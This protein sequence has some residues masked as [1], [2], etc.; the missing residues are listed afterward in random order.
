MNELVAENDQ[1]KPSDFANLG[2]PCYSMWGKSEIEWLAL[3]YVRA[4]A[5]GGDT[6]RKLSRE[7]ML[8]LLTDE[9]KQRGSVHCSVH[10][11]LKDDHY[12]QWFDMVSDQISD[13]DGAFGVGG[14]WNKRRFQP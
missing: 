8:D 2:Q 12:K 14:V 4:L 5:A 6:W 7:E 13:A 11:M 3:A 9:Q 10:L 1:F